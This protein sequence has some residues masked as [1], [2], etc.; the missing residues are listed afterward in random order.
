MTKFHDLN[1]TKEV[2]SVITI[3]F[4]NTYTPVSVAPDFTSMTFNSPQLDGTEELIVVL[5]QPYP[6]S[7]LPLVFNLGFGPGDGHG[8][9]LD[10]VSLRHADRDKVFSTI[11]A[12]ALSFLQANPNHFIGLDGSDD[13]RARIYHRMFRSN[14]MEL[15]DYFGTIGLD[16]YVKQLRNGDLETNE[17]GEYV[18]APFPQSFDYSRSSN[19]LYRYYMFFLK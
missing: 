19:Q 7:K 1:G 5:L 9:F 3:D 10:N 4:G 18:Y 15:A 13:A 8:G 6:I 17:N 12:L 11:M 14:E 16:Y 2:K